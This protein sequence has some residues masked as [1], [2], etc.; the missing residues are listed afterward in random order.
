[1]SDESFRNVISAWFA[2]FDSSRCTAASWDCS[3]TDRLT[4]HMLS[5]V[6]EVFALLYLFGLLAAW[7][8]SARGIGVD[9]G[10]AHERHEVGQV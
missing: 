5:L 10:G 4:S 2:A 8:V 1:M 9:E 6:I 3:R 7:C